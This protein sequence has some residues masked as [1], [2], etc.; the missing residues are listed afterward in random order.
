MWTIV[1]FRKNLCPLQATSICM[2]G[3]CAHGG[4]VLQQWLNLAIISKCPAH[5]RF[6][7]IYLVSGPSNNLAL[8]APVYRPRHSTPTSQV[9][10]CES[11]S[12]VCLQSLSKPLFRVTCLHKRPVKTVVSSL[13]TQCKVI[14]SHKC[15]QPRTS[16]GGHLGLCHNNTL[17]MLRM[18]CKS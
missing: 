5:S 15:K 8:P 18:K 2:K 11:K 4:K 12:G 3:R 1:W 13:A 17:M 6:H 7:S 9:N 10:G 14:W 16:Q